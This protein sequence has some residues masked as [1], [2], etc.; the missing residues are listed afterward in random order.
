V[1]NVPQLVQFSSNWNLR[2]AWASL[3]RI[4]EQ[5]VKT[6]N[7]HISYGNPLSGADNIDGKWVAF[8]VPAPNVDFTLTHNLGRVPVGYIVMSKSAACDIY[9]GSAPGTITQI[10]LR[11]TVGGGKGELF[12]I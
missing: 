7:N 2:Q 5:L 3:Q 10:T 9:T 11:G 8:A 1:P 12:I 6:V 4:W